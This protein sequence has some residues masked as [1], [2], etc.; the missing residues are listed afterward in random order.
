MTQKYME[1]ISRLSVATVVAKSNI[2][3][4]CF[5]ERVEDKVYACFYLL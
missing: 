4:E 1:D 3:A 5:I 2:D